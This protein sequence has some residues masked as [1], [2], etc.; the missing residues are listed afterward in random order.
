MIGDTIDTLEGA[1]SVEDVERGFINGVSST[2]AK[3]SAIQRRIM[4]PQAG[5]SEKHVIRFWGPASQI[6]AMGDGARLFVYRKESDERVT[7]NTVDIRS[8]QVVASSA[9]GK[10]RECELSVVRQQ[11]GRVPGLR[12]VDFRMNGENC[13]ID[14]LGKGRPR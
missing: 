1:P 10:L 3:K 4:R 6:A 8:G 5:W 2:F 7:T 9:D 11:A 14:T 13:N 12:L